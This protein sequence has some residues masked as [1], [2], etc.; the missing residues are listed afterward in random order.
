MFDAATLCGVAYGQT[1]LSR[2]VEAAG[3]TWD[4]AS[5]HSAAYGAEIA[6]DLFC[7][8]VNRFRPLFEAV[9]PQEDVPEDDSA[10]MAAPGL[11]PPGA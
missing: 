5:A 10:D 7:D 1:V 11:T 2:A 6:A 8:V 9:R 4:D 3:L